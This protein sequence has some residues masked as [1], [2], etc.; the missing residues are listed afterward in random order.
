MT[1]GERN[2]NPLNIRKG[3]NWKGLVKT[4]EEKQFCVFSSILYGIRAALVLLRTYKYKYHC[5]TISQIISRWAPPSENDTQKY[6][7]MVVSLMLSQIPSSDVYHN[8]LV[9]KRGDLVVN[10]WLNK[11]FPHS[12]LYH[13]L[14]A[15]AIV[16]SHYFIS[17][18]EFDVS[19]GLL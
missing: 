15:M 17:K 8:E 13:L 3:S 19:V 11:T 18:T 12:I 10:I 16:E 7:D 4:P 2:N 9:K 1:R 6:I 14:S 5:V